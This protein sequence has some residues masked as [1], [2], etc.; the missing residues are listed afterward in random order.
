[1]VYLRLGEVDKT[2]LFFGEVFRG[3]FLIFAVPFVLEHLNL[4]GAAEIIAA[5][6]RDVWH[7]L[8]KNTPQRHHSSPAPSPDQHH[9]HLI[10]YLHQPHHISAY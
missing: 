6:G 8:L 10:D 1:M 7:V 9:Q 3:P 4:V 2:A 5:T